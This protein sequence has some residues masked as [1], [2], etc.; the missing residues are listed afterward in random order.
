M[1]NIIYQIFNIF[2][3]LRVFLIVCDV[4]SI[5]VFCGDYHHRRHY[6]HF[7]EEFKGSFKVCVTVKLRTALIIVTFTLQSNISYTM[8][9]YVYFLWPHTILPSYLVRSIRFKAR[10]HIQTATVLLHRTQ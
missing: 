10:N 1:C 4:P 7:C 9:R 2:H 8:C 3:V 6:H 5:A